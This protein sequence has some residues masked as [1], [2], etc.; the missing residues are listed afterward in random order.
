MKPFLGIDLTTDKK[1]AQPNGDVFL[2][3]K[4]SL[5]L[6]ETLQRYTE[7]VEEIIEESKLPLPIRVIHW[8]CGATGAIIITSIIRALFGEDS[9]SLSQAYKNAS[10]L[11]WLGGAC[12]IIWGMLKVLSIRKEKEILETDENSETI[13]NHNKTCEVIFSE[14]G[15]DSS[16]KDVDILSFFYK[17]KNNKIKIYEKGM[18]TTPY[19]ST[20]FRVFTDS[21]NLIFVNLE[22]TY[23]F[24][25]SSIK[26]IKTVK[27]SITIDKWN[28]D[29]PYDGSTYK[30]YKLTE[31]MW[32]SI[33]CKNYHI[34]EIEYEDELW[35][36]Y[37]PSYE[38]PIFE[39]LT[40][41]TAE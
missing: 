28:K 36:I 41:L 4:P 5:S 34:I 18:Q 32:D 3:A 7:S 39:E 15:V 8:I 26:A 11:F 37:I 19:L 13:E 20:V 29:E 31:T 33:V 35:G 21:D 27:K 9:I 1:N 6:T 10:W 12:L 38:L 2:T 30:K 24:P 22:G 16:A 23:T 40:G 25:L 14:L 17:V